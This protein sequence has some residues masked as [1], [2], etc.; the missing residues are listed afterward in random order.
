MT[1]TRAAQVGPGLHDHRM[2]VLDGVRRLVSELESQTDAW[3]AAAR[4]HVRSAL[5][6]RGHGRFQ[7]L[8]F[9]HRLEECGYEGADEKRDYR[10]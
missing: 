5:H 1:L 4:H 2:Q 3:F 8:V 9:A 6:P 10:C 7:V